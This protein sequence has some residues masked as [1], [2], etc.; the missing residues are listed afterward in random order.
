MS[1]RDR[2]RLAA[3]CRERGLPEPEWM[4]H[5]IAWW[6]TPDG[7][8]RL[9]AG[10]TTRRLERRRPTSIT[11]VPGVF[12]GRG[13]VERLVDAVARELGREGGR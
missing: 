5:C 3:A 11:P 8:L 4:H 12:T 13:W 1:P 7:R 2:E 9:R 6:T 10:E